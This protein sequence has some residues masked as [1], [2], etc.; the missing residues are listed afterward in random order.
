[1]TASL[2]VLGAARTVTG[3]AYELDLDGTRVLVDCG[4]FQGEPDAPERNR[5]APVD[6]PAGLAAVVLTHG[7]LDHVGRL[8]LFVRGGFACKVL[9]HPATISIS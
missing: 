5:R 1:M 8:P 4:L 9:G 7:H 6:D 3:S 2:R